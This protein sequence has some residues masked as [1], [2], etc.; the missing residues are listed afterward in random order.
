MPLHQFHRMMPINRPT[1]HAFRI[2]VR[3]LLAYSNPTR[4]YRSHRTHYLR[5]SPAS[6]STASRLSSSGLPTERASR[7]A[8]RRYHN[9][10]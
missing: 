7:S 8:G 1:H 5:R 2:A 10:T 3:Y 9:L 6:G 4:G